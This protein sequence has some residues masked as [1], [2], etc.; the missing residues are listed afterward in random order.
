MPGDL[1]SQDIEKGQAPLLWCVRH[2]NLVATQKLI[3]SGCDINVRDND[4]TCAL[5]IA[6]FLQNIEIVKLLLYN[7][8]E[9]NYESHVWKTALRICVDAGQLDLTNLLLEHGAK[10]M[11]AL[12]LSKSLEKFD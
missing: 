9:T 11:R 12:E 2:N 4:G 6:V 5:H 3:N 10:T 8:A 7:G 1:D